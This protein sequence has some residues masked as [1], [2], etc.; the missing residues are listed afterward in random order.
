VSY[1]LSFWKQKPGVK[2]DAQDTY[3]RL[4]EGQ[5][6]E[7]LEDLPVVQMV[8]RVA[9]AFSVGWA[10]LNSVSWEAPQKAF[11][12]FTTSQFFRVD[13]GGM[14]GEEM[15]AFIDIGVEFGCP[16]YDP[17]TGERFEG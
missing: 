11:Q 10:Q 14:T 2:L 5:H 3:E 4:L 12:I 13:C 17:Q 15:N 6:I 7:G 8:E 16:L 9:Q 1:D